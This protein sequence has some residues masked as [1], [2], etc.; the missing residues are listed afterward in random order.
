[1]ATKGRIGCNGCKETRE[2]GVKG[3]K[4]GTFEQFDKLIISRTV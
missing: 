1:M 4:N 3:T 2:V